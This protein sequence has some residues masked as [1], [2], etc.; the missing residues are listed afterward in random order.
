MFKNYVT[1]AVR[2]LLKY[3]GYSFINIL[4]LAIGMACCILILLFVQDELSYDQYHEKAEQIYRLERI[5]IFQGMDYHTPVTAHPYGPTMVADFPEIRQK[6]RLWVVDLNV[7]DS[8]MQFSEEEVYF[9]DANLFDVFS[10]KLKL[11]DPA[12]ALQ[13]PSSIVITEAMAERYLGEKAP[14]GQTLNLTWGDSLMAFKVTGILEDIPHNSH[15]HT[16]FFASYSSLDILLAEQ[17]NIWLSNGIIT[18]LLL[19]EGTDLAALEAKF[20]PFVEKYM[21][22]QVR[23]FLGPEADITAMIKLKLFPMLDIHLHSDLEHELEANGSITTVYIFFA[24][25]FLIL[26]IAAIN[27]MNLSTARSARRAKEVGL[28]KVVGAERKFLV[29]Q[30]LGE[31]VLISL[32]ALALGVLLA[33]LALPAYNAFTLKTLSISYMDNPQGVL[34]FA[35]LVLLVG[36]VGGLY[37]AFFLSA[38]QPITVLKGTFS[39]TSGKSSFLREGL[40]VLQF[41]ISV[42]L[43][44]STLIVSDQL[45][46]VSKK[47]L[48]FN[49]EQVVVLPIL[50]DAI[51]EK[52]DVV[53][54]ELRRN[55]N[56]LN[57]AASARY[58]G[59]SGFSDTIWRRAGS[60]GEDFVVIQQFQ[61]DEGFLP[62]M[63]MELAHGRNF[64]QEF[65]TDREGVILNE[66]AVAEL[67]W[68]SPSEAIDNSVEVPRS[69]TPDDYRRAP[70]IG[71]VKNFHFKSLRQKIEPLV[72]HMGIVDRGV[73][74]VSAR[75]SQNDIPETLAFI[76]DTWT[77]FSPNYPFEYFFLDE[78]FDSQYRAEQRMQ[79]IFG[80]FTG[81]AIFVACLGLL[82]LA[83]FTAEQRTKEIGIRKVL[84]ASESS[85][86]I[87]MSRQFL[88][89]VVVAFVMAAPLAWYLM[90]RWLEDFA[91][92]TNMSW[93]SFVISGL[94]VTAIALVTVS[95]QAVKAA[96]ANPV[97][98]LQYE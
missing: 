43:I 58:P 15:F 10:F 91:Y 82:G 53:R 11:G 90:S 85:I 46:F 30:F 40:V 42:V 16:D 38:F 20:P 60:T 13:T 19:N 14:L 80:T 89:L 25:A 37:P 34:V 33:E 68:Q 98:A 75:I 26:V 41:G 12:A 96:V 23:Q 78:R 5:G 21:G 9:A 1:V 36:V 3:K 67:G 52:L 47:R 29:M 56:V 22:K 31:S 66:A 86:V 79:T 18:Y 45:D 64:S 35:G 62:T 71:V 55:P 61:I 92:R 76:K 4:G 39:K 65:E 50:D 24:I 59:S 74:F 48:G 93:Q 32:I 70:V 81:L 57:V 44:V 69:A 2:N 87:L 8:N 17:M 77:R 73:N 51:R 49:K 28:R 7:R 63:G 83:S 84:G 6:V 97:D 27:F 72:L 95:F 54:T 94:I 88:R